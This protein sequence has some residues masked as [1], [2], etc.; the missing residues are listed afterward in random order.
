MS[1]RLLRRMGVVTLSAFLCA[2]CAPEPS[3]A[4]SDSGIYR[5]QERFGLGFDERMAIPAALSRLRAG[6]QRRADEVYDPFR[7][8]EN[9][10]LNEEMAVRLFDEA[11]AVMLA[12]KSLTPEEL[13]EI[14]REYQLSLGGNLR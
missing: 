6:A 8:K 1:T 9:A 7:S 2:G 13:D 3:P 4:P 14:I 12:E 5:D 11:K 10:I